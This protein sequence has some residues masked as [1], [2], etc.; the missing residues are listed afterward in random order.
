M[1]QKGEKE[2]KVRGEDRGAIVHRVG[3]VV[4]IGKMTFTSKFAR[5]ERVS[6]VA[7]WGESI[8]G[9]WSSQFERS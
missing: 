8:S 3:G 4:L 1:E 7:P 5:V 6:P 9:R 2:N